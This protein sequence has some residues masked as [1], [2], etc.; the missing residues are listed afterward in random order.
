MRR[1]ELALLTAACLILTFPVA[2]TAQEP[3]VIGASLSLTGTHAQTAAMIHDAYR[4]WAREVNQTGGLLGR[5]VHLLIQDDQSDPERSAEVYRDLVYH[6]EV[7]L[8]LSPYSTPITVAAAAVTDHA[9]YPMIACGASGEEVWTQGYRTVFGMYALARRYFIG[10]LDLA[11]RAGLDRLFIVYESNTFNRD[12]AAGA[13]EWAERMGVQVIGSTEFNPE[14]VAVDVLAQ[15][16]RAADPDALITC[17]YVPA[18]YALLDAFER[19][20]YRPQAVAMTIV[21]VHP[22]FGRNAGPIAGGIMAPS[23]WE[24]STRIPFPGTSEFVEQFYLLYRRSPSYHAASAYGACQLLQSA[25]ESTGGLDH[26][27]IRDYIAMLDTVTV[28]GRF[29]VDAAGR[30]IGHNPIIIQWQ[31]GRKEIVYPRDMRTADPQF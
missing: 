8:I 31:N 22:D 14:T 29:K 11:A 28:L 2:A 21:P 13:R 15:E 19:L 26:E 1:R 25:V 24:P 9:G 6:Q 7:D 17:T 23:Q 4:L 20:S 27:R 12:A 5:P 16:I 10:F 18:G 3:V 30:Q